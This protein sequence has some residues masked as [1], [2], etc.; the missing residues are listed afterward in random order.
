MGTDSVDGASPNIDQQIR[1]SLDP[2]RDP[3]YVRHKT[4]ELL[5]SLEPLSVEVLEA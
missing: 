1:E 3:K 2:A 5:H 4:E